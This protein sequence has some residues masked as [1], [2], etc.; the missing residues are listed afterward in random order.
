MRIVALLEELDRRGAVL[1]VG[2]SDNRLNV[3]PRSV[4]DQDLIAA[5]REHKQELIQLV[6]NHEQLQ[7]TG[8]LQNEI[9]VLEEFREVGKGRRAGD[10]A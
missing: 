2:R 9:Q 3:T 7:R 8:E 5:L 4:L 10:A 1:R 6:R